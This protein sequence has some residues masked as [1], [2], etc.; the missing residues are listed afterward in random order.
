MSILKSIK[1]T[2]ENARDES[3]RNKQKQ[4]GYNLF[5]Y[6]TGGEVDNRFTSKVSSIKR[7]LN[8]ERIPIF[9]RA[10]EMVGE[11]ENAKE[12]YIV[13]HAY[14]NAGASVRDK[15]IHY[16]KQF[17]DQGAAWENTPSGKQNIFGYTRDLH[18]TS[19]ANEHFQLGK[20][21]E[22]ELDF[23]DAILQYRACYELCP[24]DAAGI[25]AIVGVYIKQGDYAK[26]RE[27]L[28]KTVK[29]KYY[30]SYFK[31]GCENRDFIEIIDRAYNDLLDKEH[32]GYKYRPR[33]KKEKRAT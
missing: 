4:I 28:D 31:N 16:M 30:R 3:E 18:N 29:S 14:L 23:D 33:T 19:V 25:A 1:Q 13:S 2:F 22:A 12:L 10:A 5:F 21:Y 7:E 11:P 20:L 6:M 26:G 32:R 9:I 17:V 24:Y 15:A 27:L 8:N